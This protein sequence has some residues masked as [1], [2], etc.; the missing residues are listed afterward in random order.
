MKVY[1]KEEVNNILNKIEDMNFIYT[2]YLI[3]NNFFFRRLHKRS[4]KG[5][6]RYYPIKNLYII[7]ECNKENHTDMCHI[8][9]FKINNIYDIDDS[10]PNT[11]TIGVENEKF[12][13][14]IFSNSRINYLGYNIRNL[15]K[16]ILHKKIE[17]RYNRR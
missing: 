4:K 12:N 13:Y 2:K 11:I 5:I 9:S 6:F 7:C 17:Y 15:I 1:T 10:Y 3:D 14:I 8:E 16:K